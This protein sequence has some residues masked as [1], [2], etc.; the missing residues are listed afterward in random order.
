M[1]LDPTNLLDDLEEHMMKTEEAL[2]NSFHSIRT[3]KASPSLVENVMVEYYGTPTRLK[4][5]AGIT[6]PE[7]RLLVIQPWDKTSLGAIEKA[8]LSSNIGITPM[9]DGTHIKLPIPE[10]SQE[11]RTTLAKQAKSYVEE[12][13]VALRNIRRDGNEV[14]KK[15]QKD[16]HMTEDELK[17]ML[18]DIQKLTDRYSASLDKELATKEKEL[19][20]V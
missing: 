7:P 19:M 10:L 6:A 2:V 13:K 1:Q 8:I 15:A 3:G 12:A 20:T 14:A 17:K 9:N 18:D 5:L 16:G 11:R 4:E